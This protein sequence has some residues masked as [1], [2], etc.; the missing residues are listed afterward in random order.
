[1]KRTHK[2]RNFEDEIT[3]KEMPSLEPILG[4]LF[5]KMFIYHI[6]MYTTI[7]W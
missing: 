3:K 7:S 1:M 4:F 2:I 5:K 6:I